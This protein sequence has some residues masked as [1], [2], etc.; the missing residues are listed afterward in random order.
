MCLIMALLAEFMLLAAATV[1]GTIRIERAAAAVFQRIE[2]RAEL[3]DQFRDDV[4]QA[5]AAP[6]ALGNERAGADCL[7]LRRPD[8]THVVYRWASDRLDR[9][10]LHG[11]KRTGHRIEIGSEQAIVRFG[12][13]AKDTGLIT[14]ELEETLKNGITKGYVAF[15]APL[16]GGGR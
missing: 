1:Y 7:I 16:G 13:P 9:M 6:E 2:A 15:V 8:G 10:E 11:E 14:L 5:V 4:A 12:R 3:A